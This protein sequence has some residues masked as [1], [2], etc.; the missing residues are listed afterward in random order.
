MHEGALLR[1]ALGL[2][3]IAK[4]GA[5]NQASTREVQLIWPEN[6]DPKWPELWRATTNPVVKLTR[7]K[8]PD[9]RFVTPPWLTDTED[10]KAIY[11]IGAILR[12]AAVANTDFTAARWRRSGSGGYKGLRTGWFKRRMGMIHAPEALVG[13]YSTVSSWFA[14]FLMTSLQ[15][16]GFEATHLQHAELSDIETLA[17]LRRVL[18]ARLKVVDEAACSASGLPTVITAVARHRSRREKPFRLVTVQQLGPATRS[19]TKADPTLSM[20]ENRIASRDQL[21]RTCELVYRTL[22]AHTLAGQ[23]D[24]E[25]KADLIVLPEVAVHPDDVDILKRLADKSRSMIFAGM[26]FTHLDGKLVNVGRWIIPD[27]RENG[28]QWV[29]RDQGKENMT[30]VEAT[31]GV[32]PFRPCQHLIEVAGDLEG[33]YR[34]SAAICYDATD[35]RLAADLTNKTDLFVIAAHNKDVT[36]FDSMASALH[37]HMYQHVVVV[38]K[39]EFG[40]STI[41]APYKERYHRLISHAH[42]IEQLSIGVADLDLAAFRRTVR[43]F[44]DVKEPPAGKTKGA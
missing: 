9:P 28:R 14:E 37:Y 17:D 21:A 32:T 44:K 16:P 18:L 40:G 15:W 31:F 5:A 6:D 26:V 1:I 30:R 38:N 24:A 29:I 4:K 34:I 12:A 8:S 20:A 13:T 33:P 22:V 2:I 27:F 35:L 42:G 36:T 10:A 23:V 39:G 25:S 41:Q 7:A 19:F 43:K 11:W 3:R